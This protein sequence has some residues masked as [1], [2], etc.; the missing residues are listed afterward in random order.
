MALLKDFGADVKERLA[1]RISDPFLGSFI[2]SYIAYNW[3]VAYLLW[4]NSTKTFDQKLAAVES[5]LRFRWSWLAPLLSATAYTVIYPFIR[6]A[7]TYIHEKLQVAIRNTKTRLNY[8]NILTIEE[9][10][11]IKEDLQ[12]TVNTL[13]AEIGTAK[14]DIEGIKRAFLT[15]FYNPNQVIGERRGYQILKCP[16][17]SLHKKWVRNDLGIAKAAISPSDQ[18]LGLVI[19]ILEGGFCVVQ[20]YGVFE[21][22]NLEEGSVYF[23]SQT[24]AGEMVQLND[25]TN[26]PKYIQLGTVIG[27]G[28]T[29]VLDIKVDNDLRQLPAA[30]ARVH[31]P[32]QKQENKRIAE[33]P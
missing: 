22:G 24:T 3:Q 27:P 18:V 31:N 19:K 1:E 14:Q 28:T 25:L 30:I 16:D 17:S 13:N 4:A 20:T 6:W 11:K 23:L 12:S 8:D 7:V 29:K 26:S 10:R 32:P 5:M 9:S 33:L 21:Y 15:E 2:I